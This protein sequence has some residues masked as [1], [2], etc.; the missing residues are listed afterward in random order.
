[1]KTKLLSISF[2]SL[3]IST[4]MAGEINLQDCTPKTFKVTGYYSP[5]KDQSFYYRW[6]YE[7]EVRLNWWG[8]R[9]ASWRAVFNWMIAAPKSYAFW[10]KIY[11]PKFGLWEVHDRWG[12]IV[13]AWMRWNSYDRIDIWMG[14]WEEWLKRALSFWKKE[15]SWYVCDSLDIKVGFDYTKFSVLKNFF[16]NSLWSTYLGPGRKD[17]RVSTL[18]KYLY[19]AGYLPKDKIT[20]YYWDDTLKALCNYQIDKWITW[21]NDQMCWHFWPS[22]RD[23]MKNQLNKLRSKR[24]K[25]VQIWVDENIKSSDIKV[26]SKNEIKKSNVE[27]NNNKQTSKQQFKFYKSFELNQK[28]NEIITL[29]KFL[30]SKWLYDWQINWI[31]DKKTMNAVADF[32]ISNW[33]VNKSDKKT[34]WFFWP[35]TRNLIN[36]LMNK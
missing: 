32:Q 18:Q 6:T 22:T 21:K 16:S 3:A 7:A 15:V 25:D 4:C 9:W 31:Y 35:K 13:K 1:M 28:S 11:F 5:K 36:E 8:I 30:N 34:L 33:L 26:A 14:E 20:W 29:Q 27:V 10:T 24:I 19:V 23:Y 17:K 12:A 2:I